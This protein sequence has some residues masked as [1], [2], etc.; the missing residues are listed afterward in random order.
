MRG[1][2]G[3]TSSRQS[4]R[5]RRLLG[6]GALGAVAIFATTAAVAVACEITGI[7]V[8]GSCFDY[9]VSGTL[10]L[11]ASQTGTITLEVFAETSGTSKWVATGAE[12][13]VDTS[14][15]TLSYPYQ[16]V[17]IPK[18][19]FD[20]SNYTLM[21]IQIAS[22]TPSGSWA[23]TTTKSDSYAACNP[24]IVPELPL[25]V[26]LPIAGLALFTGAFSTVAIRR[27]RNGAQ[28]V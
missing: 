11:D 12:V 5:R 13:T 6:V 1:A 18:S 3:T 9:D 4:W 16:I 25:A 27:R 2:T 23:G 19:Y 24:P 22:T 7:T 28:D 17:G 10:K 14:K 8:N 26:A 20:T 21:D 15:S